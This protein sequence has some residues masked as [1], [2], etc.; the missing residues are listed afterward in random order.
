MDRF[1]P[2]QLRCGNARTCPLNSYRNASA[3]LL[4]GSPVRS[5]TSLKVPSKC[6]HHASAVARGR[7]YRE[8]L[9]RTE[10]RN[11]LR[12]ENFSYDSHRMFGCYNSLRHRWRHIDDR[13]Y[14][15]EASQNFLS[16]AWLKRLFLSPHSTRFASPG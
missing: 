8:S 7:N 6:N 14:R 3:P 13:C 10:K 12:D 4:H 9:Y 5:R 11:A 15:Q 1:Y 2:Q 16:N